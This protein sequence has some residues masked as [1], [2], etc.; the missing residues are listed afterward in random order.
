MKKKI[1][2]VLSILL[3]VTVG[4]LLSYELLSK[5]NDNKK[6][7]TPA[8]S[9]NISKTSNNKNII[10]Y[11][12]NWGV[13]S[14]E[15]QNMSVA[16][17]PWD[18]ITVINHAFFTVSSSFKLESTDK[19]ADFEKSFP[20]SEGW[21][22][23]QLRGHMG[24]YKYYK[25]KYPNVKV[26]LSVGGWTRGENFHD[27]AKTK[28]N[29]QT[30]INSIIEF[31]NKYPFIDGI[32]LDWEYPGENREKDPNDDYDRGCPGGPE[33]KENFILLL[34]EIRDGY[35]KNDMQ[36]KSLTIANTSNYEKLKLQEPDKYIKY[37]DY[38]NVMT[39]DFHG[40]WENTTNHHSAIYKNNEDPT[41]YDKYTY[42]AEDSMKMYVKEYGIP[43][44]KLNV[45]SPF[46]SRG[47]SVVDDSTGKDGLFST[48]KKGYKGS[49][50]GPQNPGGQIPWFQLKNMENKDGWKKYF[51]NKSKVPYLYN[52]ELKAMLTYEDEDSLKE[53]CDFV[54]KNEYGGMIIWEISGDDKSSGFPLTSIIWEKFGK[55]SGASKSKDSNDSKNNSSKEK[56]EATSNDKASNEDTH[57]NDKE[58]STSGLD[59]KFEIT[60]DWGSGANWS[61]VITNNTGNDISGWEVSF[62]FPKKITQCWDGSF[63]N[64]GDTY[65]ISN[66]AWGG[67]LKKG[68]SI[69]VGGACEG[70]SKGLSIKNISTSI[71]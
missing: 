20:H 10:M 71:K 29:R 13:Y 50:D 19:D 44:E 57:S 69:T 48:A 56:E 38:I 40:S 41:D 28:E 17:I 14:S 67:S 24:E 37:L 26:L 53:R 42:S 49:W 47:W 63:S 9:N 16:D 60:S 52:K 45:G 68:D 34:K 55:P 59:T 21:D 31:L 65:K 5:P 8:S 62:S 30:F 33:D 23:N 11:F 66:P 43:S 58:T 1:T 7:S 27:M 35:N 61:M 54:L 70:D 18:K 36:D 32:D 22:Q 25:D 6:D 64:S 15:H 2:L 39:Y 46:Y 4:G 51:D 3:V 12:P